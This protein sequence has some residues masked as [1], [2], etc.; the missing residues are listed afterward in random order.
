MRL[1]LGAA[2]LIFIVN[3]IGSL[4]W[5]QKVGRNPWKSNS[6]EWS[7]PSPP[8]HGN[9]DVPPVVYRGPYEYS[10]PDAEED[11]WPQSLPPGEK[12]VARAWEMGICNPRPSRRTARETNT[13]MPDSACVYSASARWLHRLAVLTVLAA[14]PLV[15]LGAEV[16]SK[17]V[18]MA[19]PVWPTTPW[20]ML[21]N[22]MLDRG[23]GFVIEHSH[24][25]AG[26][27]VGFCVLALTISLWKWEPRRWICWLGTAAGCGVLI[28]GLLGGM[29]VV[30]H[31]QFGPELALIHGCF[32][33]VVF[34]LLVSV[35]MCTSRG[36]A[37]NAFAA[38]GEKHGD[39]TP[40]RSLAKPT[41]FFV[42]LVFLQLVF[43]ALLRHKDAAAGKYGH[44]LVAFAVLGMAV[45]L[46][47]EIVDRHRDDRPLVV[48]TRWFWRVPARAATPG[49]RSLD[50]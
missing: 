47:K 10:A 19:D 42:G 41:L 1:I 21:G 35:A 5:G 4:F 26:W 50:D 45:W 44:L 33:Q 38:A 22:P 25:L 16:T 7:A 37:D 30:R 18:G 8:P 40:S 15:L 3:L 31:A 29:R 48:A 49:C 43:G 36:W 9:F 34:A 23:I 32:G 11:Y 12:L 46:I 20:Y 27:T 13:T 28:Q 17:K 14:M 39:G 6:L 2:Q 24:R